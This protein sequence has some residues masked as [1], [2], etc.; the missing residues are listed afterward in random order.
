M[1]LAVLYQAQI[2]TIRS[3]ENQI[4]ATNSPESA[5][6][7][8]QTERETFEKFRALLLDP[9]KADGD[10]MMVTASRAAMLRWCGAEEKCQELL[11]RWIIGQKD[12]FETEN[13]ARSYI[14]CYLTIRLKELYAQTDFHD[15]AQLFQRIADQTNRREFQAA[16]ETAR[17]FRS[18]LVHAQQQL[19]DPPLIKREFYARLIESVDHE[20]QVIRKLH[21]I[22]EIESVFR[23]HPYDPEEVRAILEQIDEEEEEAIKADEPDDDENASLYERDFETALDNHAMLFKMLD[24]FSGN[25]MADK[26]LKDYDS[27]QRKETVFNEGNQAGRND[28]CPCGSGKKY[29]T[30]CLKRQ[31]K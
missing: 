28:P 10:H 17:V 23:N 8:A 2:E 16:Y 26:L 20:V 24:A 14:N 18:F 12:Q 6:S 29:K 27:D 4:F 30:C 22:D 15:G 5:E 13:A 19:Q 31:N 1:P 21:S 11:N 3:I 7:W 9:E 25:N